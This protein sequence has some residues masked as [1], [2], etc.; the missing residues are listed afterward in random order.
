MSQLWRYRYA[1]V[2]L[3]FF[4]LPV[5]RADQFLRVNSTQTKVQLQG[6]ALRITLGLDNNS[7]R[8]VPAQVTLKLLDPHGQSRGEAQREQNIP[9]GLGKSDWVIQLSGVKTADLDDVFWYRLQYRIEPNSSAE[10]IFEPVSGILTVSQI[11]PAMF[12]L[13]Y[14]GP[15][16]VRLGA[17][18]EAL[19]RAVQPATYEPVAGVNIR[20]TADVSDTGTIPA[21]KAPATT[22]SQG[23]ARLEFLLPA[24]A[25]SDSP[26]SDITGERGG[27]TA[28]LDDEQPRTFVF[29]TFR[30]N[31]DK[32]LYQP[33]QT[34]HARVLVV[35]PNQHAMTNHSV[36]FRVYDPE[37][38]LMFREAATTS[39]FGI[40]ST[41]WPIP[42]NERLGDYRVAVD[43][44]EG[45]SEDIGGSAM[46]KISRYDLPTFTVN[47]KPNRK[48][49]LPRQ[50]AWK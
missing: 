47:A 9:R 45:D 17:R 1:L 21:L 3:T 7:G 25:D 42:S 33:G 43:A 5:C 20:A 8:S 10:S 12:R 14:A 19:V 29:S 27:Y 36:E 28:K 30:V 41:D 15:S 11:A 48:Y 24:N 2:W 16:A 37:N 40:A 44:G 13:E 4:I 49:Y 18:F 26:S 31:T 50:N 34:L 32:A 39:K 46:V 6:D 22:D 35:G 38:T 23:Y